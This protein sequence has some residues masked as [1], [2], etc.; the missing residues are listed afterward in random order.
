[1]KCGICQSTSTYICPCTKIF[2]CD[3]HLGV[4]LHSTGNHPFIR[5]E[6]FNK[7]DTKRIKSELSARIQAINKSKQKLNSETK[8]L[9]SL[10]KNSAKSTTNK[11]DNFMNQYLIL[12]SQDEIYTVQNEE[13]DKAFTTSFKVN[14]DSSLDEEY[15]KKVFDEIIISKGSGSNYWPL[16]QKVDYVKQCINQVNMVSDEVKFSYDG[17]YAFNCNI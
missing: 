4:H 5:L 13:I 3:I 9:L 12:F 2:L 10:I 6:S 16:S 17:N 15:F 7:K 1:M 8:K 11:L 14:R